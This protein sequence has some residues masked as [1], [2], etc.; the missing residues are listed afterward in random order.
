M[1]WGDWGA[2]GGAR[3]GEDEGQDAGERRG[4]H[5]DCC[6]SDSGDEAVGTVTKANNNVLENTGSCG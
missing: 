2:E 5:C 1:R 4:V 6:N 3:A